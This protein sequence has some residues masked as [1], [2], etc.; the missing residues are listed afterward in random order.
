MYAGMF[1]GGGERL[2]VQLTPQDLWDAYAKVKTQLT[3]GILPVPVN[4]KE[5]LSQVKDPTAAELKE[6]FNKYKDQTPSANRDTPGFKVPELSQIEF[7]YA[8]LRT[9]D[10]YRKWAEALR[11]LDPAGFHNR[12]LDSYMRNRHRYRDWTPTP[13]W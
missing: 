13:C 3:V 12:V 9:N 6:F 4:Q 7:I 10:Y 11:A 1:G 2:S 8:D 5:F